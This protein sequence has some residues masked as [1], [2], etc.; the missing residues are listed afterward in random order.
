MSDISQILIFLW[1]NYEL[2]NAVLWRLLDLRLTEV[3][4]QHFLSLYFEESV[5]FILMI[6]IVGH[7]WYHDSSV[8]IIIWVKKRDERGP[9]CERSVWHVAAW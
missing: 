5:Q 4:I 3:L 8:S 2:E 1:G 6:I 9:R 7:Q